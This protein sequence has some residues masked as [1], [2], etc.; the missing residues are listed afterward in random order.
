[1][2]LGVVIYFKLFTNLLEYTLKRTDIENL[3]ITFNSEN[4]TVL[5]RFANNMVLIGKDAKR[6]L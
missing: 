2:R 4:I 5:C 3:G 1:M 6:R